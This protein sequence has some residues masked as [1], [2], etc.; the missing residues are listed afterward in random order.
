MPLR[1]YSINVSGSSYPD[2]NLPVYLRSENNS[3]LNQAVGT[4]PKF[5]CE[6][7]GT[8][9]GETYY[10]DITET[11]DAIILEAELSG[12][13]PD[14]VDVSI[15]SKSLIIE[16][17]RREEQYKSFYLGDY[18]QPACRWTIP[19]GIELEKEKVETLFRDGT[20]IVSVLKPANVTNGMEPEAH[21]MESVRIL[22]A[23]AV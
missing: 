6:G 21:S 16:A 8:D 20:L 3:V 5:A 13:E 12:F 10:L 9:A 17:S 19:I 11:G 4:W 2:N 15:R 7:T 14:E 22:K 18:S 23:V 1:H